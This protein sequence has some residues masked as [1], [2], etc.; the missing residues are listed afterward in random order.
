MFIEFVD[1]YACNSRG[2]FIVNMAPDGNCL[3]NSFVQHLNGNYN[4]GAVKIERN[5]LVRYM[6]EHAD[7][8][9]TI[10][11]PEEYQT[12][13]V[14]MTGEHIT[15]WH[16]MRENNV[17]LF[18]YDMDNDGLIERYWWNSDWMD[19][20]VCGLLFNRRIQGHYDYVEIDIEEEPQQFQIQPEGVPNA[21]IIAFDRVNN[22]PALSNHNN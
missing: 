19:K 9:A 21:E 4:S 20:D 13:G 2:G 8:Y 17:V 10:D 16:K 12:N 3:V 7:E 11:D 18:E 14:F 6:M 15:A 22:V 1:D 5:N